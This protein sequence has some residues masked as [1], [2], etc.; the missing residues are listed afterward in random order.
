[1]YMIEVNTMNA[2]QTAPKSGSIYKDDFGNYK[3]S[4]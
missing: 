3:F 2:D 4:H 1:M